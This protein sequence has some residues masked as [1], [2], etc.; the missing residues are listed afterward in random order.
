MMI[1]ILIFTLHILGDCITQYADHVIVSGLISHS[2]VYQTKHYTVSSLSREVPEWKILKP[3]SSLFPGL[4]SHLRARA[5]PSRSQVEIIPQWTLCH[6]LWIT[7]DGN[8]P[9]S[10]HLGMKWHH[11]AAY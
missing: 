6:V 9:L 1:P 3:D 5:A 11:H 7:V 10:S 4:S 8:R 2:C